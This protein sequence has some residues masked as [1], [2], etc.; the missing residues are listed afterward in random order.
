MLSEKG[1]VEPSAI[2]AHV[3]HSS[4][5]SP[6]IMKTN[7]VDDHGDCEDHGGDRDDQGDGDGDH[8]IGDLVP[9]HL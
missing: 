4:L 8:N 5:Y 2:R 9:R 7:C 3:P 6:V 1:I